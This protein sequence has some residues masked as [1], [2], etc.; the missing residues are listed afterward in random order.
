VAAA[1]P[2]PAPA[3]EPQVAP[4]APMPATES[5][6][7][8]PTPEPEP[9]GQIV[10]HAKSDAWVE[11]HNRQGAALMERLMRAGETWT[12]PEHAGLVLST[13]NA[14]G[15]ELLVDGKPAPSLGAF[16]A[17]RRDIPLNP[18]LVRDGRYAPASANSLKGST[19]SR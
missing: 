3:S 16:G 17:V 6:P 19:A 18:A 14:G 7:I 2:A 8:V 4:A 5:A 12:V 11:V 13:G 9:A 10:L 1:A 15:L